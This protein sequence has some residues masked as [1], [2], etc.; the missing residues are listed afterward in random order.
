MT[1][2]PKRSVQNFNF[3]FC[4]R[5]WQLFQLLQTPAS[6]N[7]S[8]NQSKN[9]SIEQQSGQ[10]GHQHDPNDLRG[11]VQLPAHIQQISQT[12][13]GLDQFSRD[14]AMPSQRPAQFDPGDDSRQGGRQ[15]H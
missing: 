8:F 15:N 10:D 2:K 12:D 6:A 13:G 3:Q 1:P 9:E 7:P 5:E 4:I 11:V 14:G